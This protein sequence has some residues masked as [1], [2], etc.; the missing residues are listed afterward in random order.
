MANI[1]SGVIA[2]AIGLVFFLY[3][4]IRIK[5]ITGCNS[6]PYGGRLSAE[7]S[8]RSSPVRDARKGGWGRFFSPSIVA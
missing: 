8:I 5:S 4:A 3:Y 7:G 6:L 1:I 2:M